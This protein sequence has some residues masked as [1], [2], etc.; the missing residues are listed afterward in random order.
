[1]KAN[2][3]LVSNLLVV[4]IAV[5]FSA[6]PATVAQAHQ[7]RLHEV[8]EAQKI[9]ELG[10]MA[11]PTSAKSPEAQSAFVEGMLLLHLFEYQHAQ[12][13]FRKAQS[14]DPDF[15]LAYW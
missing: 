1:M 3:V 14:L 12:L 15:A 11:F 2:R 4:A 6:V 7:S 9:D 5:A 8:F 10:R 13:A